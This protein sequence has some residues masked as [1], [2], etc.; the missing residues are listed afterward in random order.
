VT[1]SSSANLEVAI[2]LPLGVVANQLMR[3]EADLRSLNMKALVYARER[4]HAG[5]A[6]QIAARLDKINEELELI[7][8]LTASIAADIQSCAILSRTDD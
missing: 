5:L 7:R 2:A 3:I 4:E 8:G 6:A 1:E